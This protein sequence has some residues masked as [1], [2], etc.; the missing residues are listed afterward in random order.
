M[1]RLVEYCAVVHDRTEEPI[2][3]KRPGY[4]STTIDLPDGLYEA[5]R[6]AAARKRVSMVEIIRRALTG[7][8]KDEIKSQ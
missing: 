1:E 4:Q 2:M 8:L 7:W 3:P 5:L 6:I